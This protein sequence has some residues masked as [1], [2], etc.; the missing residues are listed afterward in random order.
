MNQLLLLVVGFVTVSAADTTAKAKG[1]KVTDKVCIPRSFFPFYIFDFRVS[2]KL[3][4]PRSGLILN[5]MADLWVE[6]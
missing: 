2:T 1:P 4:L 6:S 3:L 5:R